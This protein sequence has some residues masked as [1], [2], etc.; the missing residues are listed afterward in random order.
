M[1]H[2]VTDLCA[3]GVLLIDRESAYDPGV[4]NDRLLLG[5]KGEFNEMELRILRERTQAAIREKENLASCERSGGKQ[6]KQC[7]KRV[8][9][10]NP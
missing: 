3:I 6:S 5:F 1:A 8:L 10:N 7:G 9:A 4:S 2:P